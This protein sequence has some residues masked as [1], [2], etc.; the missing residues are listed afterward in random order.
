MPLFLKALDPTIDILGDEQLLRY[1]TDQINNEANLLLLNSF[2]STASVFPSTSLAFASTSLK[3]FHFKHELTSGSTYG[4]FSLMTYDKF[5]T[6]TDIFK[7]DEQSASLFFFKNVSLNSNK[8][9]NLADGVLTS[10]AVNLRQLNG[11]FTDIITYVDNHTWLSSSITDL[12]T[13]VK[14][15]TLDSFAVPTG[16]LSLNSNKITS[17]ADGVLTSDAINVGQLNSM[18]NNIPI[19]ALAGYP[20]DSSLYLNGSGSW[21]NPLGN[22]S[23]SG[24]TISTTTGNNISFGQPIYMTDLGIWLRNYNDTNHG[25]FYDS[26]IDGIQFKGVGG[27]RWISGENE[28]MRLTSSGLNL[29]SNKITYL[30]DP[31]DLYDGANKNFVVVEINNRVAPIND[32]L[33]YM[34]INDSANPMLFSRGITVN[35]SYTSYINEYGAYGHL[36]SDGNTGSSTDSPQYDIICYGRIRS[37]EFNA[38]SSKNIKNIIATGEVVQIEAANIIQSLPTV[39]YSYKD[40]ALD[41]SGDYYGMISEEIKDFLPDYVQTQEFKFAPNIMKLGTAT[42]LDSSTIV[43]VIENAEQDYPNITDKKIQIITEQ[44][45]FQGVVLSVIE[46]KITIKTDF[47]LELSKETINVFVY[48]TYEDCPTIS[49]MRLFDMALCALQNCLSRIQQLENKV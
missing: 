17:L 39:K 37:S 24:N 28:F 21:V 46:N 33:Q 12:E 22:I 10:D 44:Q 36:T 4:N 32:K 15:Y 31:V 5:G 1:N 45:G 25:M 18:F 11:Q 40:P 19:N 6:S 20:A 14:A 35:N 7:Y 47:M 49:K 16:N 26:V 30:A 27:F 43:V 41:G 2:A 9:T 34:S 23:F 13:T 38:W 29:N 48:G 8:I 42:L 3:G